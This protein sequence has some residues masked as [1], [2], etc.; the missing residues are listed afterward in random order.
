MGELP[1]YF[2]KLGEVFKFRVLFVSSLST[3]VHCPSTPHLRAWPFGFRVLGSGFQV[4][5]FVFRVSGFGF[6][7][8][9]LGFQKLGLIIGFMVQRFGLRVQNVG[10]TVLR[11]HRWWFEFVTFLGVSGGP[12]GGTGGSPIATDMQ[13]ERFLSVWPARPCVSSPISNLVHADLVEG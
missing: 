2:R 7:D 3:I 1:L 6:R 13:G 11:F 5:G 10:C 9:G 4:S 12:E 8:S